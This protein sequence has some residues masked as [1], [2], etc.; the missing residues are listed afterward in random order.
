MSGSFDEHIKNSLG[1][2]RPAVP[3]DTWDKIQAKREKER[4]RPFGFF[5]NKR[6]AAIAAILLLTGIAGLYINTTQHSGL[7]QDET[8]KK[9]INNAAPKRVIEK[10][11]TVEKSTVAQNSNITAFEKNSNFKKVHPLYSSSQKNMNTIPPSLDT[12]N[13]YEENMNANLLQAGISQADLLK[14]DIKKLSLKKNNNAT[15]FIPCPVAEKNAAANKKYFEFYAGPDF[16]FRNFSDTGNGYIQTRKTSSQI[17]SAFSAGIRYTRVF[18]NGMSVRGG[19]NVRQINESFHYKQGTISQ[20]IFIIDNNGDT[21]GSYIS[22]S[23]R[24]KTYPNRY[25]SID[26]PISVG[27]EMGNG[28]FH[29]NLN[30]GAVIN[31]LNSQKGYVVDEYNNIIELSNSKKNNIYSY[32]TKTGLGFIGA[33]SVYYKLN[34]NLHLMAEPYFKYSFNSITKEQISLEQRNQVAGL[35][36]GLRMDL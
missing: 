28:R 29:A 14:N 21:T 12:L 23:T 3:N 20:V 27:Y 35:K 24:Y 26:I 31:I 6:W 10:N 36:L 9:E 22:Q 11:I 8:T 13:A 30:I 17:K 5:F 4:H 7:K 33:A 16:V 2:Y 25:R 19:I 1:N 15:Y 32:K 34:E 18:N